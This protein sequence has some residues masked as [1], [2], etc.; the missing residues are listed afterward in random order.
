[1]ADKEIILEIKTDIKGAVKSTEKL[2]DIL[3]EQKDILLE[4]QKEEIKLQQ[5]RAGMNKYEASLKGVDKQLAHIKASIK[6]QKL[7][8]KQLTEE[9]KKNTKEQK[10]NQKILDEGI[11]NFRLFGVSI[12]DVRKSLSRVIPTIKLMFSTITRGI[13][14]TGIGVFLIALGSLATFFTKTQRGAD[15]LSVAL[16]GIGAA[17]NVIRDRISTVGEA[18]ALLFSGD[19]SGAVDKIK[20][21]FTGLGDEIKREVEVMT[22]LEK[23]AKKLR[24]AEIEFTVQR[25][26][27]RKEIE[28]ARLLA[29]DETKSQEER[30]AALQKALDLETKTTNKELELA[31]EKVKIQEEQMKISEN[32]VEDEKRLADLRA[33]LINKETKS[34]RLQKRVKT[35]INEL[36]RE[37]EREEKRIAKEKADAEKE[38][39]AEEKRIAEEKKKEEE[40]RMKEELEKAKKLAK[41]KLDIA[42]A[43][44]NAKK[45]LIETS[46]G[47]ASELA[48]EQEA[49]S[50][51]VAVAQT[52]YSTQQG[53][54]AAMAATSV[55]DKLLPYPVRLANAIATGVMGASAIKKILS[56]SPGSASGGGS[57]SAPSSSAPRTELTGGAFTLGGGIEPEPARAFV[58]S[59]DITD[60]QNKLANI[61]RRAT[62]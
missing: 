7:A 39:L 28:K 45:K 2:N 13:L 42:K 15:N 32:L 50:K 25:A 57:V 34:F 35:E 49:L 16:K 30:V 33:D 55:A 56:T 47:V 29:E 54:M 40:K 52:I 10:E 9:Q 22:A 27:T 8:V 20:E 51:A 48:G 17:F 1:M 5:E 18:M 46:F 36:N 19:L 6:D 44:E 53:I 12:N 58:V 21:S 43:E 11:G 14:S 61:R 3:D 37:I 41:Q 23:R 60:S 38:R 31:R 4:L 26:E 24:D 62:I 59:D